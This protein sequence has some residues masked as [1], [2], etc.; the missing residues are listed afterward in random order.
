MRQTPELL[1]SH[2]VRCGTPSIAS[3]GKTLAM[4]ETILGGGGHNISEIA[5][6]AGIPTA[7]AHRQAVTLVEARYLSRLDTGR[8]VAGPRL[9][10]LVRLVDEKQVVANTAASCLHELASELNCVVQLGT[11]ENDMV[12]YRIKTGQG[13]SG[14]FTKV[15]MQLEAYCSGIGKVLL[16]WL[17]VRERE[18]YLTAGPFPKLTERTITD[19]KALAQELSRVRDRGFAIDDG[20]IAETLFCMAVPIRKPDGTVPA[21]ISASNAHGRWSDEEQ[22]L[23][24]LLE[25]AA[26]IEQ[27]AFY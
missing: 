22:L 15:D 20:E 11:L 19:P 21:A 17:P 7:T 26:T 4:L 25:A 14:L 27:R 13:A 5:R 18:A 24:K 23:G 3:F 10:E 2:I 12:T 6:V 1:V 8:Y 9:L 16:A